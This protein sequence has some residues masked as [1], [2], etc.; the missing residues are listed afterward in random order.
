MPPVPK[1]SDGIRECPK[2]LLPTRSLVLLLPERGPHSGNSCSLNSRLIMLWALDL[3]LS[4]FMSALSLPEM[5]WVEQ[6]LTAQSTASCFH[7]SQNSLTSTD[8]Q[9]TR[10]VLPYCSSTTDAR[11]CQLKVFKVDCL[12]CCSCRITAAWKRVLCCRELTL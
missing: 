10:L 11:H 7:T 6:R 4:W 9:I 12:T 1:V 8:G 3:S 2:T 5:K